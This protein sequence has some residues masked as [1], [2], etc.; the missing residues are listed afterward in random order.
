V[1]FIVPL[2]ILRARVSLPAGRPRLPARGNPGQGALLCRRRITANA[3]V[4][5][6][7][8]TTP[9]SRPPLHTQGARP[10]ATRHDSTLVTV[11]D[12]T[13]NANRLI[14]MSAAADRLAGRVATN[15]WFCAAALWAKTDAV[16]RPG[17]M[18]PSGWR[19]KRELVHWRTDLRRFW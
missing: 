5:R 12:F 9:P 15:W 11:R 7:G 6:T 3:P 19:G 16:Y 14:W 1:A 17:W 4:T 18:V 10:L 8:L 13:K 2:R